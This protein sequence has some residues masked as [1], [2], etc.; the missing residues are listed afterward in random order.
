MNAGG[1]TASE[2][3]DLIAYIQERVWRDFAQRLEPEVQF[4]GDW[5]TQPAERFGSFGEGID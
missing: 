4:I 5:S 3:A 1:A 2:I